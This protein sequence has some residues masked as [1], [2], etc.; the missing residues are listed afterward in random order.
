MPTLP[1]SYL[2][3]AASYTLAASLI[4]SALLGLYVVPLLLAGERFAVSPT[5]PLALLVFA[6]SCTVL[7]LLD[8]WIQRIDWPSTWHP[9]LSPWQKLLF[10]FGLATFTISAMI[11]AALAFDNVAALIRLASDILGLTIIC[12]LIA[13]ILWSPLFLLWIW[14][15]WWR[16]ILPGS[17]RSTPSRDESSASSP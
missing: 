4:I 5:W 14:G 13:P 2:K 9:T 3:H 6:A 11:I 10:I 17:D 8:Q 12:A 1:V 15:R 7:S 16:H